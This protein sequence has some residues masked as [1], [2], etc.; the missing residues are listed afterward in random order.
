[1]TKEQL[2]I[3]EAACTILSQESISGKYFSEDC[4]LFSEASYVI[5][6]CIRKI[7]IND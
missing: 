7:K 3:V 1:M 5:F 2:E 6:K 4:D